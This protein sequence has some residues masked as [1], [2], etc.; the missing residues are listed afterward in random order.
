VLHTPSPT[1]A[2]PENKD[3]SCGPVQAGDAAAGLGQCTSLIDILR[4]RSLRESGALAYIFL[5]DGADNESRLTFR[6]LFERTSAIAGVLRRHGAVGKRAMLLYEPGLDYIAAFLGTLQAGAIAVPS[7]PPTGTRAINRLASIIDDAEPDFLLSTT[8][9]RAAATRQ[10]EQ[11]WQQQRA[12][13]VTTDELPSHAADAS[14]VD[15]NGQEL[16]VLQYTSGSTGNPKGVMVTHRNLM[17][18]AAAIQDWIGFDP[19]PRGCIWLPPFHDMGLMGGVLQPLYQGFPVVLFSPAHFVQQPLRWFRAISRHRS[20]VTSAP[21]F[22]FDLCVNEIDDI[23]LGDIDLSSLK[24]AFCGAEP[25]LKDTLDRFVQRFERCGL[26]PRA[27]T[28]CYGMAETTLIVSGKP[29]GTLPHYR[30]FEPTALMAGRVAE[31]DQTTPGARAI[32]SSGR[33]ARGLDVRIVVPDTLQAA[34]ADVIGEIWVSGKHVGAGYWGKDAE[35][36][37]TFAAPLAGQD[38]VY[39]R[40][41]DLGF[42][43]AGELFVTG[44]IKD[45]IIIAGLNHYPQDIEFSAQRADPAIQ[46]NG[47]AAFALAADGTEALAIVAEIGRGAQSESRDKIRRNIMKG[48]SAAHGIRPAEI[49]LGRIGSIPRTTSGKV[50]RQACKRAFLAGTLRPA[51]EQRQPPARLPPAAMPPVPELARHAKARGW[52]DG[53]WRR[54]RELLGCDLAIVG[55]AMTWISERHLVAA[56]S[57]GGGFGLIAAGSMSPASLAAE[58]AATR[59]LTDR[60]FGVNLITFRPEILEL[61]EVSARAKIRNIVLAGGI[62]SLA[63]ITLVK[64]AGAKLLCFAPTLAIARKLVRMG[65]DAIIIEGMEAGGHIGPV[66]TSVLAQEIL[67]YLR[68]VPVFVAGGIGS[69][70]AIASYLE[71]GASGVQLGTRFVCARESIAH[72]RFKQAFIRASAR[73]AMPSVQLDSRFPVIPV[74]ALVNDGTR[75]FLEVQ[76]DVIERHHRGELALRDAQFEI[77]LFWAGALRRAAIDGDVETGSLMAGQSVGMVT[78]EQRVEEILHDLVTQATAALAAR[79]RL[80]DSFTSRPV[81]D[82]HAHATGPSDHMPAD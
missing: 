81:G 47:V 38:R 37:Q 34:A 10:R 15:V 24:I 67:P 33:I 72:P 82:T 40:T 19:P 79:E 23:D 28:P 66:S 60:P 78:T 21:N 65:A 56:I 74:R 63:A 52:L 35:T 31:V 68:E 41:G 48:V 14:A 26:D 1:Q 8:S 59:A 46:P 13:W 64:E 77:E 6:E 2:R 61:I 30:H 9:I 45:V 42:M 49:Y 69:G 36:A 57:N 43:R 27:L 70:E 44:R 29:P 55:G 32:A 11:F 3:P 4:M 80:F 17:S 7:Y 71:M 75:R 73:D 12:T 20:T 5:N 54:G 22:A 76:R 62:P 39:L 53:L 58:I 16:A 51:F 50:Q 25:V 18:N